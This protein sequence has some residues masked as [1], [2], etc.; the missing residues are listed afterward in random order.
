M[1]VVRSVYIVS[2]LDMMSESYHV[3]NQYKESFALIVY[4]IWRSSSIFHGKVIS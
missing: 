4:I 2:H 3:G 1:I